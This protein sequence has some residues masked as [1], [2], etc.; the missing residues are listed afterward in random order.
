MD[1]GSCIIGAARVPHTR[2]PERSGTM[3]PRTAWPVIV[4]V[5]VLAMACASGRSMEPPPA[6]AQRTPPAWLVGTWE[7]TGYK[8]GAAAAPGQGRIT[9]TFGADGAW[10]AVTDSGT[11]SGKSWL[12]DDEVVLDGAMANGAEIRYTL[13]VRENSGDRE[14]W[15]LLNTT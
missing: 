2:A 11:H 5:G 12:V 8:V 1:Q 9:I 13:R 14:M 7:G 3:T 6:N 4:V 15:G 10:T